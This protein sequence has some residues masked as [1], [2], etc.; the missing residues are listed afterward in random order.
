MA[1]SSDFLCDKTSLSS[2]YTSNH[3][4]QQFYA[5]FYYDD[6]GPKDHLVSLLKLNENDDK[7]EVVRQKLIRYYFS[8][9]DGGIVKVEEFVVM[10]LEVL[11]RA[12]AWIGRDDTAHSLLYK[13]FQ[14]M[15]TLFH[16]D[17]KAKAAGAKRKHV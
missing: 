11:P 6:D 16:T 1:G 2:I 13:L 7:Q 10:E 3:T 4:L 5:G 9:D 8:N 14:I 15:P 17:R 12:I